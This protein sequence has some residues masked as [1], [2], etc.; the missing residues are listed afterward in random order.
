M[1]SQRSSKYDQISTRKHWSIIRNKYDN[2]TFEDVVEE[3]FLPSLRK[4]ITSLILITPKLL[5]S[6]TFQ[7]QLKDYLST[8][9]V[10]I[11]IAKIILPSLNRAISEDG[12]EFQDFLPD[13]DMAVELIAEQNYIVSQLVKA[14]E[15]FDNRGDL[16]PGIS[17]SKAFDLLLKG[18]KL[19]DLEVPTQ[20][21]SLFKRNSSKMMDH[22]KSVFQ[23][24]VS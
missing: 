21:T 8:G 17:Y 11:N 23:R 16:I 13:N 9:F 10:L 5:T 2:D 4:E 14:A 22:L 12:D 24:M 15:Q 3:V 1:G 19:E 6:L 20:Y 18:G 7:S